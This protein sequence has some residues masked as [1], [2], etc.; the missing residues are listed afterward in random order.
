MFLKVMRSHLR[1][2]CVTPMSRSCCLSNA[3]FSSVGFLGLGLFFPFED[4]N[5]FEFDLES[6]YESHR[7]IIQS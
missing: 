2:A 5:S 4:L 1:H 6:D 3:K 7:F